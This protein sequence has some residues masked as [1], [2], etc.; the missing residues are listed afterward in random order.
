MIQFLDVFPCLKLKEISRS[1]GEIKLFVGNN[2]ASLHPHLINTNGGIVLYDTEFGSGRILDGCRIGA[3]G[4]GS[5]ENVLLLA[6]TR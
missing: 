4:S 3:D 1:S 6:A 5:E 2:C